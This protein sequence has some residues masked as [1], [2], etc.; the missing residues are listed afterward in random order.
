MAD[1]PKVNLYAISELKNTTDDAIPPYMK[2]LGFEQSNIYTDVRLALGFAACTIAGVTFY[3]DYTVSNFEKTKE[4]TLYAVI[5]YFVLNAILTWWVWGVEG[6]KVFV[7]ERN[8]VKIT[9]ESYAE[10]YTPVYE[11]KITATEN[12][13]TTVTKS[14]NPFSTWYNQQGYFVEKPFMA[15]LQNSIPGLLS[16]DEV[17]K[18]RNRKK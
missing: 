18:T 2:S 1:K 15:F 8:G 3:Y 10:K 5:A 9:L 12:G 17:T 11:L 14:K 16:V 6:G 4:F 7:G 13:K